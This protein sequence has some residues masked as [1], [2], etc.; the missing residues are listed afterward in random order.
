[1]IIEPSS[2]PLPDQ[3]AD[4]DTLTAWAV[5]AIDRWVIDHRDELLA[6]VTA[7]DRTALLLRAAFG[8]LVGYDL[9]RVTDSPPEWLSATIPPG[10]LPD[11]EAAKQRL[12]RFNAAAA[13]A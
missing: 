10:L 4:V 11:V 8:Y 7:A 13:E 1:M 9:V 5:F 6:E 2:R 12:R 3:Q